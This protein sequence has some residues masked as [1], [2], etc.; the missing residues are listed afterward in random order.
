MANAWVRVAAAQRDGAANP[1]DGWKYP[2][3]TLRAAGSGSKGGFM[4]LAT[5]D[6]VDKVLAFYGKKVGAQLTEQPPGGTG[7]TGRDGEVSVFQ[8]DSI[9]PGAK[10]ELRPVAVHIVVQ[11][12]NDH[13]LALVI[14]RAKGEDQTH[15]SVTFISK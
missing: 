14:S 11:R 9:Q 10:G 3:A 5:T 12:T 1:V 13:Y 8:D 2:G 4:L 15:I 6:P 7:L